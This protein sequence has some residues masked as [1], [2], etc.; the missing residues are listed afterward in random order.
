MIVEPLSDE[1]EWEEFVANSS[2]G[3]FFHTLKWKEVFEK[4]FS[5]ESLYLVI[6]DSN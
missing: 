6:R 4:L 1:K 2:K 3:T 5:Y